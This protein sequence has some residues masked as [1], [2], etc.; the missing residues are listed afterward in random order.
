MAA[1]S[2]SG[3]RAVLCASSGTRIF[4]REMAVILSPYNTQRARQGIEHV[5]SRGRGT[6]L[7]INTVTSLE[8]RLAAMPAKTGI[9]PK[10]RSPTETCMYFVQCMIVDF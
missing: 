4:L 2:S 6:N 8:M 7:H 10:S 3:E 9:V 5:A 1:S